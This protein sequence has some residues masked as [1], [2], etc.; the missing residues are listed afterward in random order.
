[1]GYRR[2]WTG[3]LALGLLLGLSWIG[4]AFAEDQAPMQN[5]VLTVA[6]SVMEDIAAR[7]AANK[8]Q[9]LVFSNF[10]PKA[11]SRNPDGYKELRYAYPL[12]EGRNLE[13]NVLMLPLKS[14][15]GGVLPEWR[16]LEFPLLDLKVV[17]TTALT[18]FYLEGFDL[19]VIVEDAAWPL[20]EFQQKEL[21]LRIFIETPKI[22][23]QVGESVKLDL[24][25]KNVSNNQLRVKPLD[26]QTLYCTMNGSF[27]GTKDPKPAPSK[28]TLKPG[29]ELRFPLKLKGLPK[30]GDFNI[31]CSYGIGYQGVRPQARKIL[32]IE[33]N[34]IKD[35]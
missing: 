25:V 35:N 6:D 4:P 21:P 9:Y 15:E 12:A 20:V 23:Y 8:F 27:W 31:S 22:S 1:M 17:W 16:H 7:I 10:D 3:A 30:P 2:F 32:K 14:R 33:S 19:D 18:G 29:E 11:M 34:P 5:K 24:V 26:S 13:V 28:S